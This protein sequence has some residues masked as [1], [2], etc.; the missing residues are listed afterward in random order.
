MKENT[1][2]IHVIFK[3]PFQNKFF[4]HFN[5]IEA[6]PHRNDVLVSGQAAN[7]WQR[8]FLSLK[9]FQQTIYFPNRSTAIM[10]SHCLTSG[11]TEPRVLPQ[12]GQNVGPDVAGAGHI[13]THSQVL[14]SR[15]FTLLP[16]VISC[17]LQ[18]PMSSISSFQWV[19]PSLVGW[20]PSP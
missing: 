10:R 6:G 3:T 1:T 17:S 8:W 19:S 18:S 9:S 2:I 4:P 13:L 20:L 5:F 15:S 7:K 16:L 11:G 14:Y 12:S